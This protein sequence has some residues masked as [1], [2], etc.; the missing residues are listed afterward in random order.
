M[1][2]ARI[3]KTWKILFKALKVLDF[4]GGKIFRMKKKIFP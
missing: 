1:L 3:R 4:E 2:R